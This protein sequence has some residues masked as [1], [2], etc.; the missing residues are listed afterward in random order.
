MIGKDYDPL[1]EASRYPPW[2]KTTAQDPWYVTGAKAI[3]GEKEVADLSRGDVESWITTLAPLLFMGGRGPKGFRVRPELPERLPPRPAWMEDWKPEGGW[4]KGGEVLKPEEMRSIIGDI[5]KPYDPDVFVPGKP[6]QPETFVTEPPAPPPETPYYKTKMFNEMAN[7]STTWEELGPEQKQWFLDQWKPGK[8][9][10]M[11]DMNAAFKEPPPKVWETNIYD[12]KYS[13]PLGMQ[14][15]ANLYATPNVDF[16]VGPRPPFEYES[17]LKINPQEVP[18]LPPPPATKFT[19][20]IP[21]LPPQQPP[22][23]D[24]MWWYQQ[25][26][27]PFL[28]EVVPQMRF[29]P[30]TDW[31]Q[32]MYQ[33]QFYPDETNW[34][35]A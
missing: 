5:I 28:S 20:D 31:M 29:Y 12:R 30:E 22:Q 19:P 26:Q 25:P 2:W 6:F 15:W 23:S 24:R 34:R 4:P 16:T 14:E 17:P 7:S 21:N 11:S 10:N 33:S 35:I 32:Q 9:P 27:P 1:E 13:S 18:N 8:K 3:L